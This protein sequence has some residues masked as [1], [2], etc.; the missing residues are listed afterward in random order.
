MLQCK[1][2]KTVARF[3]PELCVVSV[4]FFL[5]PRSKSTKYTPVP[6]IVAKVCKSS[7]VNGITH[8][9]KAHKGLLTGTFSYVSIGMMIL[10]LKC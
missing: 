6:R 7:E 8:C 5:V 10:N 3:H 2:K 4:H 1:L 9:Q